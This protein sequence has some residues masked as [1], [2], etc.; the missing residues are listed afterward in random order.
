M[1]DLASSTAHR[2]KGLIIPDERRV[3]LATII[4]QMRTAADAFDG[5]PASPSWV[6]VQAAQDLCYRLYS[7]EVADLMAAR[8]GTTRQAVREALDAALRWTPEPE[9][10][11]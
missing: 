5:L 8:L 6:E 4:E 11:P 7:A 9:A 2:D 10:K 1:S 3:L